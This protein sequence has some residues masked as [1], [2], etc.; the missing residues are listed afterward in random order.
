MTATRSSSSDQPKPRATFCSWIGFSCRVAIT[1]GSPFAAPLKMKWSP[2]KVLP[3][4]RW[5]G[6]ERGAT[7]SRSPRRASVSS[8]AMPDEIRLFAEPVVILA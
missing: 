1:P 2:I 4:A 7:R 5:P 6:H 8:G 3:D